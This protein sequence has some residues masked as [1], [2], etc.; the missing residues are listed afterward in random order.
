MG[1]EWS[2]TLKVVQSEE[3]G[4]R[5]LSLDEPIIDINNISEF[6]DVLE[7]KIREGE[8]PILL[9]I[10]KTSYIG[11]VGLGMISLISIMLQ[12]ENRGFAVYVQTDEVKRLFEISGLSKVIFVSD[13]LESAVRKLSVPMDASPTL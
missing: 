8:H 12:K 2:G 7:E 9:D 5:I 1:T 4:V 3:F 11:S 13:D 6:R 10:S